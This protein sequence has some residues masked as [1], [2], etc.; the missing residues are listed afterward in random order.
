MARNDDGEFELVLGNR[1]LISV[2]LIVVILLAVFFSMGY[3]VGR[4]S[5]PVVADAR[6]AP[7]KPI[8]VEQPPLKPQAPADADTSAAAQPQA[9]PPPAPE[10]KAAESA[11][12]PE[13]KSA[14]PPAEAPKREAPRAEPKPEAAREAA[15]VRT[16]DEPAAGSYWQVVATSRPEAEI[17]AEVLSKKGLHTILTPA[18]KAGLYR[19]LV[20]P[21]ANAAAMGQARAELEAAGFK[22]VIPKKY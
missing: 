8:V 13:K 3:I 17:V 18:P 6:N 21:L 15:A 1:Q 22:S 9:P 11:P 20:G 10:T 14:M 5:A 4:N 16:V 12:A 19:V 7:G 2:F